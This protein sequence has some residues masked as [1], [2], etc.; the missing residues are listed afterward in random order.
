MMSFAAKKNLEGG[1]TIFINQSDYFCNAPG[2]TISLA[3]G[4]PDKGNC[5]LEG[6]GWMITDLILSGPE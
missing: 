6:C 3:N 1:F 5:L 4:L 2:S